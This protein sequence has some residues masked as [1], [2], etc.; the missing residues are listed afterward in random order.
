[1]RTP[2]N[3]AV[4]KHNNPHFAKE[5]TLLESKWKKTKYAMF[6][7][8]VHKDGSESIVNITYSNDLEELQNAAKELPTWFNYPLGVAK[9]VS[10]ELIQI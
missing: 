3:Y 10:G 4:I 2:H 6:N 1:M 5:T 8:S 9:K 7:K